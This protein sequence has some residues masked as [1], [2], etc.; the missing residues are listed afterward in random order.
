MVSKRSVISL[1][2]DLKFI[3]GGRIRN[4]TRKTVYFCQWGTSC[5]FVTTLVLTRLSD[6][7]AIRFVKIGPTVQK[8]QFFSDIKNGGRRHL[9]TR[10]M[11]F[12]LLWVTSFL[13]KLPNSHIWQKLVKW[14]KL[15]SDCSKSRICCDF[16]IWGV[17]RVVLRGYHTLILVWN[18]SNISTIS[19]ANLP[20]LSHQPSK[21][22]HVFGQ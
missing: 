21:S 9:E 4:S 12:E 18:S 6:S 3:Q 20:I 1:W 10:S 2:K 15:Y 13:W 17:L 14:F 19:C 11:L 22:V 8:L 7:I 16:S 5:F